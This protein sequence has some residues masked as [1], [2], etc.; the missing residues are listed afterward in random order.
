MER[1]PAILRVLCWSVL[2]PSALASAHTAKQRLSSYEDQ[3]GLRRQRLSFNLG[4]QFN[5]G[6]TL[7]S[8]AYTID[9]R[10][11]SIQDDRAAEQEYVLKHY[12]LDEQLEYGGNIAFSQTWNRLTT[13]RQMFGGTSDSVVETRNFGV[14]VSHWLFHETVQLGLDVSRTLLNRPAY[15]Y[16]GADSDNE[17]MPALVNSTG[18]AFSVK[19]LA[20][21]T[22]VTNYGVTRI[23]ASNRPTAYVYTTG[24]KQFIPPTSSAV[25]VDIARALNKGRVTRYSNY[26]EVSAWSGEAAF[27]Q[28]LWTHAHGKVFY[29]Y[30]REDE[31]TRVDADELTRGSDTGGI[32][33]SQE[34]PKGTLDAIRV[35]LVLE[36]AFSRYFTNELDDKGT[37]VVATMVEAGVQ[38][39]F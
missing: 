3:Q 15:E 14:G 36:A 28:S 26:G 5:H 23:D 19:H 24:I 39:K 30:Y 12:G 7:T 37:K 29:R 38:A 16:L 9:M 27:L 22:T 10:R 11:D 8:T 32:H 33:M 18:V 31:V 1:L 4:L 13:T 2:L 34:I 35:P 25:H 6:S 21:P 17:I 20:T